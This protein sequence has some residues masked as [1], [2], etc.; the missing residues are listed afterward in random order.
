LYAFV[1]PAEGSIVSIESGLKFCGSL[2]LTPLQVAVVLFTVNAVMADEHE[3]PLKSFS[4]VMA[5]G[6]Y[7]AAPR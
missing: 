1:A 3:L 6:P 7:R 5:R 4:G 2:W